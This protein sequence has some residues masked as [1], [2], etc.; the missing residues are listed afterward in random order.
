MTPIQ[1]LSIFVV[2]LAILIYIL[3]RR[4]APEKPEPK[5][6]EG[7][8][9]TRI[10]KL[11]TVKPPTIEEPPETIEEPQEIEP[12]P[13]EPVSSLEDLTGVGPKYREL[14][15]AAGLDSIKAIAES[16]PE[17]LYAKLIEKNRELKI[18][19]RPPTLNNIQEW[20]KAAKSLR[21]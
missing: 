17:E 11:K 20:V 16:E 12:L 4:S 2:V 3:Q 21:G 13:E 18:T 1:V 15:K 7:K 9:D 6:E 10:E 19:K 5:I 8:T 14:L